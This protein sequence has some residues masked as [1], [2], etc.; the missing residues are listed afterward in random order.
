MKEFYTKYNQYITID[1]TFNLCSDSHN[2][3]TY[4]FGYIMGSSL[5][6]KLV[7]FAIVVTLEETK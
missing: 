3:K 7:P 2:G 5:S 6:L 4:K 1:F